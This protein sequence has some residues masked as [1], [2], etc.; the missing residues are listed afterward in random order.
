VHRSRL[1]RAGM[2]EA[3]AARLSGRRPEGRTSRACRRRLPALHRSGQ[4]RDDPRQIV[5]PGDEAMIRRHSCQCRR[6]L[7]RIR[8]VHPIRLRRVPSC[9]KI[10]S[11]SQMPR[12]IVKQV[13]VDRQQQIDGIELRHQ[14]DPLAIGEHRAST[15]RIARHRLPP[16]P[17]HGRIK[18]LQRGD[19]AREGGRGRGAR[20]DAQTLAVRLGDCLA[21]SRQ[22]RR[23]RGPRLRFAAAKP[24]RGCGQGRRTPGPRPGRW[25][26]CRPGWRDAQGCPRP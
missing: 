18:L 6:R 11:K 14:L 22:R 5:G 19:L 20:Y 23:Q 26:C 7:D 9:S 3:S 1:V 21:L 15:D 24:D 25:R 13:A 10:S 16:M 17:L 4:R 12:R 8:S 2:D